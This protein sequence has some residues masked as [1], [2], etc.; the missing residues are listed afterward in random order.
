MQ[1]A[2]QLIMLPSLIPAPSVRFVLAKW[3]VDAA[4]IRQGL[5][6]THRAHRELLHI[7]R[8]S[9]LQ[10]PLTSRKRGMMN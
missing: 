3:L 10:C 2:C 4:R 8:F 9:C 1:S 6:R 7:V 5:A